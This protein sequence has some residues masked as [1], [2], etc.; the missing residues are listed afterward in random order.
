MHAKTALIQNGSVF[1]PT[2]AG[3]LSTFKREMTT[4]PNGRF[5]DQIDSVSQYLNW[6]VPR[7]FRD[8]D[9]RFFGLS[10]VIQEFGWPESSTDEPW[11]DPNGWLVD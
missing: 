11:A 2:A 4:F 7:P 9:Y 10:A 5:D 8:E 3:W 1:L 6:D